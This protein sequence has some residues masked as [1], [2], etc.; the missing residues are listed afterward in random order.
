ML[1]SITIGLWA[2][3]FTHELTRPGEVFYSLARLS[4]WLTTADSE[5]QANPDDLSGYKLAIWKYTYCEKCHAG[6]VALFVS[7]FQDDIVHGFT[8]IVFAMF[9]A[10]TCK[11]VFEWMKK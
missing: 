4:N 8:I 7:F 10:L 2:Y 3:L 9:T 6:I 11:N 5:I 1:L